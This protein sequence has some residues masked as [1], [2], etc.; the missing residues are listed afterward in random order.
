LPHSNRRETLVYNIAIGDYD[1]VTQLGASSPSSVTTFTADDR[2]IDRSAVDARINRSSQNAVSPSERDDPPSANQAKNTNPKLDN[3][4]FS[5]NC[6]KLQR[7]L[8]QLRVADVLWV[9]P[10]PRKPGP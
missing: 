4:K 1:D 10:A 6:P 2:K 9:P 7:M 3:L 5:Q 8:S